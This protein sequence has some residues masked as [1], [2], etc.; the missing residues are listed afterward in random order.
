MCRN[1]ETFMIPIFLVD[2][3][4]L[5]TTSI[6]SSFMTIFYVDITVPISEGI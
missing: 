1:T 2:F 6:Y 4:L 3:S 5:Y